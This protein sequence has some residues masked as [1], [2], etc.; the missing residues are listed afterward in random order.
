MIHTS[1]PATLMLM[2][3]H[4]VLRNYPSLVAA[5]SPRLHVYITQRN[6]DIIQIKSSLGNY[7][8][9]LNTIEIKPPFTF[10]LSLIKQF[11]KKLDHGFNLEVISEFDA[12]LGLGSSAATL[13]ATA[14]AL[15]KLSGKNPL[16]D[17][18]AL[19][20]IAKKS[21]IEVQG[22]GS[23]ADLAAA[24][25]GGIVYYKI[26]PLLMEKLPCEIPLV[27]I[28]SGSKMPTIEVIKM[29]N[30]HEAEYQQYFEDIGKAVTL[31]KSALLDNDM[32]LLSD[33]LI[34]NQN[35]MEQMH[36]A[37]ASITH[38]IKR[39]N[40]D[41]GIL[42]AKISGSGLGDCIIGL[43]GLNNTHFPEDDFEQS[44]GIKSLP[45]TLSPL[46]LIEHE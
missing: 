34:L 25:M 44:Q 9:T 28:Y 13:M 27:A 29:I 35:L 7:E 46:G 37:N 6:D 26:K 41:S 23:G 43:G 33:A 30:I 38:I 45:L 5:A 15:T 1:A 10:I 12:T 36:L 40:L 39:L 16:S 2:G 21:L 3:E 19:F 4:A 18:K 17:P 32:A 31:A 11:Q 14:A 8:C 42:A 22:E 20:K 24:L